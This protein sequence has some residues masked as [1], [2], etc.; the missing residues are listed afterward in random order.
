MGAS[1]AEQI[2]GDEPLDS[3]SAKMSQEEIRQAWDAEIL[4]RAGE[5][6]RGECELL[7]GDQALAE[8]EEKFRTRQ[9]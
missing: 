3:E 6:I 7:D 1:T 2:I 4:R 8:L 5:V 9:R